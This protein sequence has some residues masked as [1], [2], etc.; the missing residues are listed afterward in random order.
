MQIEI[1]R[2]TF[3]ALR[4][5]LRGTLIL[6]D[7]YNYHT[8]RQV[9]NGM[10]DKHPA[11]I[12]RCTC[13]EDVRAAMSSA[14]HHRLPLAV[15]GGGH[16]ASGSSICDQ[17][18]VIDLSAMQT[19]HIDPIRR[20]ACV[21]AGLT[22][23]QVIRATQAYGLGLTIGTVS[24]TGIAGLTLGG[25][26][27]WLMGKYGL[28]V[29][30]LLA[31]QLIS[32]D[33]RV[34]TVSAAENADLF[35]AI[36]GGGGN[37]GIVTSLTFQLFPLGQVLAGLVL[38]PLAQAR[39]VFDIYRKVTQTA[40]D[41]LT[42][43]A[44]FV[45]PANSPP[46]IGM[47]L[48]YCGANLQKGARIIA[49]LRTCGDPLLDTIQ[50]QSYVK[51]ST[52]LDAGAQDG[53]RYYQK[54]GN[55]TLSDAAIETILQYATART[56]P[57][58]QILIQHI[59]GVASRVS[60]TAMA[61]SELRGDHYN[62]LIIATWTD[63]QDDTIHRGWAQRFWQDMQPFATG[64]GYVNFLGNDAQNSVAH[65]YGENYQRLVE[66]KTRY[67]PLNI[68]QQNY[69]IPPAILSPA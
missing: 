2:D 20:T 56:S 38:Y 55:I 69:N 52:M 67:D 42:A 16:S 57:L 47:A 25:G 9:W 26:I 54:G 39:T 44:A 31:A 41:E 7:D 40:P 27:G 61:T 4:T 48:C 53:W 62:L 68:F 64:R 28:T 11:A 21:G 63:K 34:L 58:T 23:G 45:C 36:R 15:R 5:R 49:P 32:A 37:F 59:H 14:H 10:V 3:E 22:I 60:P 33:G 51:V 18:M 13:T 19:I 29:D 6:P 35:W 50:A 66:L 17:G 46:A 43:Y 8:A 65:A 12:I 1:S 24:G 30:H